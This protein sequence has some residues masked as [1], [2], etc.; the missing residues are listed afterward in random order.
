[1]SLATR[2]RLKIKTLFYQ[3][4]NSHY[5]EMTV[6]LIISVEILKH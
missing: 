5:N 3:Y 2:D 1:M 6:S 4:K